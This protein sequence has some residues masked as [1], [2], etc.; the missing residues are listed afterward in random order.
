MDPQEFANAA[1]D[2]IN[3]GNYSVITVILGLAVFGAWWLKK[4]DERNSAEHSEL[5]GL[6]E[7]RFTELH[8]KFAN[9]LTKEA[10]G[11]G[12]SIDRVEETAIRVETKL[13]EHIGDH[14]R[15]DV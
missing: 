9:D 13:D 5:A 4:F 8:E 7:K 10:K 1:A 12:R 3:D 6:V 15:G 11:L 2:V 14:A